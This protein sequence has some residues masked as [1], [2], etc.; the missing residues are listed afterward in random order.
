MKHRISDLK[1]LKIF[2]R[3][4]SFSSKFKRKNIIYR[5]KEMKEN[6]F[7]KTWDLMMRMEIINNITT[8]SK[9]ILQRNKLQSQSKHK[10]KK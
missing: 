4:F 6:H 5:M 1:H 9:K 7:A 10:L 3:T 8:I 2:Q